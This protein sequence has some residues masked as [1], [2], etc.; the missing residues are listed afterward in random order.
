MS[1]VKWVL[2]PRL[3]S[4]LLALGHVAG[5]PFPGYTLKGQFCVMCIL[6]Q[7]FFYSSLTLPCVHFSLPQAWE[8]NKGTNCVT[9]Y[10]A[11]CETQLS[12]APRQ[13]LLYGVPVSL[14]ECFSYKVCPVSVSGLNFPHPCQPAQCPGSPWA[15]TGP[16]GLRGHHGVPYL[17]L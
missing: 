14:K 10:L 8:V 3:S 15:L 17:G 12:Q 7:F 5:Y 9:S 16:E 4:V 13:G 11:D 2:G 1:P 6:P